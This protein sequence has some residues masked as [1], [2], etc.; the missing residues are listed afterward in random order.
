MEAIYHAFQHWMLCACL[1]GLGMIAALLFLAKV[2]APAWDAVRRWWSLPCIQ[3]VIVGVCVVG[4]SY[5]GATKQGWHVAYDGGIK[6]GATA[7]V[8][9][10]DTVSIHWQRDTSGGVYVPES[11]AVYIDYRPNT[12]TNAEWGLLAQTTVGAWGWSGTV[13][14]ATNYDYNVWAYYIPPEPVHTNGVWTYKTHFDR[15]GEY[16]LPLRARVEVNGVAIATPAEKR[17][18]EHTYCRAGLLAMWDGINHGND[19][20]IWRDLSGNGY[21]ATQRV[22]NAGWRWDDDCYRGTSL[23]GHGFR[24]PQALVDFFRS[25]ITNHTIEIVYRPTA[26]SRE[27]IFGQYYGS[28]VGLN[29]EYAPHLVG[30]FRVYWGASPD[31]NSPAWK[32]LGMVRMTTTMLCNGTNCQIYENGAYK[33]LAAQPNVDRVGVQNLIIGGENSRSNMSIRGELCIVRIYSRALS[34]DEIRHNYEI[35]KER[36]SLP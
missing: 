21:D 28:P 12:A 14:N 8:V 31:F 5:Y 26:S 27:T 4:L 22:A 10:N 1:A 15:N 29:I 33:A 6:A 13:E 19:P 34:A 3:R 36:F 35:D 25:N 7:N 30:H 16:A 20:L 9:T 17:K 11:A 2:A 18:D 24:T 23:N 32:T